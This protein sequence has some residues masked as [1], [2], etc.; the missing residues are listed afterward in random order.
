M[1]THVMRLGC[2]LFALTALGLVGCASTTWN[3]YPEGTVKYSQVRYQYTAKPV[4]SEPDGKTYRVVSDASIGALTSVPNLEQRGMRPSD[5]QADVVFEV[6]GGPVTH[7]PGSFGLGGK[8][9]P[10]LIS[11]MPIT[12]RVKD[13]GG[14]LILERKNQHE[15]ALGVRGSKTFATREEAK[16]AMA[17]VTDLM[18]KGAD[19]KV[20]RGAAGAAK[21]NIALISKTLFEP[22]DIAVQLPAIRSAGDV[23]MEGAYKLLAEA[24]DST[25]VEQALDAYAALGVE[26]KKADGSEDVLGGYGVLCGAASAKV[27]SGDLTGAWSDTKRA[28]E[29]FPAGKEARMIAKVLKDQEREAGVEIIPEEEWKAMM[30]ADQ[31][32][33]K[34]QLQQ[35]FGGGG[36]KDAKKN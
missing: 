2:S 29:R 23:D 25:Q 10:A 28:W 12:I 30:E 24:D 5:G 35:L 11:R 33:M 7:E 9:Q 3:G 8:Y 26:H 6:K 4:L 1:R 22:R 20:R 34:N 18:K 36:S 32:M 21:K 27:L 19:E 14:R 15:E 31:Q 13:S 16:A 17:S